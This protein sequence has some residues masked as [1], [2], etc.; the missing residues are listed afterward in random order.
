MN[1]VH[2][3]GRRPATPTS[4]LRLRVLLALSA[5]GGGYTRE[6]VVERW[7]EAGMDAVHYL[8][9][10]GFLACDDVYGRYRRTTAGD[11]VCPSRREIA[12]REAA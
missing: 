9:R 5:S 2:C 4:G 7:G 8:V 6:Q 11:A 1:P 12:Q 10:G 3:V